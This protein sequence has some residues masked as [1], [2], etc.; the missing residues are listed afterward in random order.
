M[1]MSIRKLR[2]YIKAAKLVRE[3]AGI[4]NFYFYI[5][6]VLSGFALVAFLLSKDIL[7]LIL[8]IQLVLSGIYTFFQLI[9]EY[10][11]PWLEKANRFFL[12]SGSSIGAFIFGTYISKTYFIDYELYW[13]ILQVV[14]I[15]GISVSFGCLY[16]RDAIR[17]IKE[18]NIAKMNIFFLLLELYWVIH[19]FAVLYTAVLTFDHS[20]FVGVNTT[21][22][23][24][25]YLDMFYFS[26]VTFTTLGYGDIIPVS[27]IAKML[28][29]V[30]VFLF[31]IV[32][33][34]V[35]VNLVKRAPSKE[36]AIEEKSETKEEQ[37]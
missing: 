24:L 11:H 9:L 13:R 27:P 35:V 16:M 5:D 36:S 12:F 6:F 15:S 32:I 8:S 3:K 20:S 2:M 10:K 4:D 30:E 1:Q 33:S 21:S 22:P 26:T 19:L 34:L 14:F 31:V 7:L 25:L 28:V 23:F 18:L 29:V 37:E 17:H